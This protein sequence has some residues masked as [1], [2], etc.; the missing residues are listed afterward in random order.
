[1][2]SDLEKRWQVEH[3][4]DGNLQT[5]SVGDFAELATEVQYG[6]RGVRA[7]FASP[8]VFGAA[9]LASIGGFSYGT[10]RI[11]PVDP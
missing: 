8:Y 6:Y 5:E 3:H 2:A 9:L 1:M 7:I 4:E 11:M 10:V